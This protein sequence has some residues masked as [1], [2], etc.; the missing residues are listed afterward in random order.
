MR[1]L[2]SRVVVA[3]DTGVNQCWAKVYFDT[4]YA[5]YIVRYYRHAE[6]MGQAADYHTD[7]KADAMGTARISTLKG[8]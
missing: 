5:E 8:Y 6:Y 2:I 7:N 4:E 3:C 1:R